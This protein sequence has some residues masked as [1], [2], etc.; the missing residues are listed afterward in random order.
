[1]I[2]SIFSKSKPINF[3]IVFLITLAAFALAKAKLTSDV[4]SL[5]FILEQAFIFS[6]CYGS[7]L[8]L[9]F[10]VGKNI[11]QQQ[12]QTIMRLRELCVK[13]KVATC[14]QLNINRRHSYYQH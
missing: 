3:L 8:V 14:N 2:T 7:I 10:I 13:Q 12:L 11:E 1:M 5:A 9:N 4:I 6:V